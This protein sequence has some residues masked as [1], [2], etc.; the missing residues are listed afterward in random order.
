MTEFAQK[1]APPWE[2]SRIQ[3]ISEIPQRNDVQGQ[4]PGEALPG[5]EE[6]ELG[7][8]AEGRLHS[9]I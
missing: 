8:V 5:L 3:I 9:D 7:T 4:G 2:V 6:R 1:R